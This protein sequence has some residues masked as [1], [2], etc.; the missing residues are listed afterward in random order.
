[1]GRIPDLEGLSINDARVAI[2][3]AGFNLGN[4]TPLGNS[5]GATSSNN[6][7]VKGRSDTNSLLNYE[8]VLDFEYYVYTTTPIAPTPVPTPYV[9]PV[10]PTPIPT[11]YVQPV[12]PTPTPVACDYVDGSTYCLNVDAQGYG[13]AYQR[14]FPTSC[15]DMY[16]GRSFCGIPAP[17]PVPTP[18]APT[19]VP[20]APTP[21]PTPV[22][23]YCIDDDATSC[24]GY[25]LYQNRYDATYQGASCPPR[26]IE[27][28]SP[29]CGYVAPTP[30]PTPVAPTPVPVAP[31]P[32]PTPVPT[33]VPTPTPVASCSGY[34]FCVGGATCNGGY[35]VITDSCGNIIGCND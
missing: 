10:A 27:T 14:G 4:E 22:A 21:V 12:A 30:A 20:V 13:D 17:T 2:T 9:Q 15:P 18:V 24:I 32:A 11:P 33:P 1:M 25:N 6:N 29:A 26:L 35:C 28:N 31:T 19:P 34:F 3:N 16:L 7:K 23:S 5:S 8:S